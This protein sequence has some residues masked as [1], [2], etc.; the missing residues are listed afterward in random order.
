MLNKRW[1]TIMLDKKL[2]D[3]LKLIQR[4]EN[5][6]GLIVPQVNSEIW[7]NLDKF[8]KHRDLRTSKCSE[9]P[10]K[11]R[12]LCNLCHKS[13]SA[14]MAKGQSGGPCQ[15]YQIQYGDFTNFGSCFCGFVPSSQRSYQTNSLG[16]VHEF[17]CISFRTG[18]LNCFRVK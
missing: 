6:L 18:N 3:K 4:P 7:S 12:K 11:S 10:C 14:I 8:N 9:E 13:A 16:P 2:T 5:C 1:A 17:V 15:I